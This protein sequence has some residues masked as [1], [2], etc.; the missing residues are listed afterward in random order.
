MLAAVSRWPDKLWFWVSLVTLI[1]ALTALAAV[2]TNVSS[3]D[4]S[5]PAEGAALS[6]QPPS[7]DDSILSTANLRFCRFQQ[8]RLEALGPLTN[9]AD[10]AV[11]H[12]LAEDW[13]K[14]CAD[15]GFD[16]DE[17]RAVE[18]QAIERRELLQL[19]GRALLSAWR[20]KIHLTTPLPGASNPS[21]PDTALASTQALPSI[22]TLGVAAKLE[23]DAVSWPSPKNPGLALLRQN[24]A[25]RVQRRLTE[26]GYVV[27]PID[28]IWGAAS[29]MALRR[30]KDANGLLQ[31]DVLDGETVA[32]L[33]ST[34]AIEVPG[35]AVPATP[36]A[37]VFPTAYL[38]PDEA[39]MNPLNGED[40]EQIQ[41]RLA[42][43]GYYAG[44]DHGIWGGA[45]REALRVF[46]TA[47][48]LAN[49][50]QWDAATERALAEPLPV[51]AREQPIP[52][53]LKVKNAFFDFKSEPIHPRPV[54]SAAPKRSAKPLK[55]SAASSL[56]L[57]EAPRPPAPIPQVGPVASRT[58]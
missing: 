45:S 57:A 18:A 35:A 47:N 25:A 9:G 38:P 52:E 22:I 27:S 54:S 44:S 34:S 24:V 16:R 29:R 37:L 8:V 33:F 14:R 7:T 51:Q 58:P 43:L 36:D 42:E 4:P 56:S 48:G 53:R 19:E 46:K 12:A 28:G 5:S 31:D 10:L 3:P 50:D 11:F 15:R 30:F 55:P 2:P 1:A 13:N 39:R 32:R 20:R 49:D 40:A 17:R 26:L 23:A 41:R 21:A 6:E